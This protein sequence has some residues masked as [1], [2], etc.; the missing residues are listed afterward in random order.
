[1]LASVPDAVSIVEVGPR[2]GL[3][4]VAELLSTSDKLRLIQ[5][6]VDAGLR[7]IEATSFVSP[8]WIPQLA[9]ADALW[10]QLPAPQAVQYAALVPNERG[11]DRA[12]AAG[13]REVGLFVSASDTHNA[14]NRGEPVAASL[15]ALP[16]LARRAL[17]AGVRLRG[18]VSCVWGCPYEGA[19]PLPRVLEVALALRR[20]GCAELSLGDTIGVATPT[21]VR[22]VLRAVA[23][24]LPL[25]EVAL[26]LHDTRGTALANALVGLDLGV[27]TF[28][29]AIAGLGGCPYAQGASGNLAT[30]DL[31]FML[32][33]MGVATGVDLDRLWEAG[34]LAAALLR[35]ALPGKVHQAGVRW[36]PPRSGTP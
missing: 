13:A 14:R 36:A 2:D 24:E 26:H 30:E 22:D 23:A 18:Y 21:A 25:T 1:M 4:N 6:L 17:A 32:A 33:G 7:R 10:P 3:Q 11:L 27:R 16:A 28:D 15:R 19:V 5:A 9:D 29:A 12:L 35:R 34:R 8:R 20:A 31:A